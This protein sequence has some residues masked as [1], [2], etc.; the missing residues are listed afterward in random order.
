MKP[1]ILICS[2]ILILMAGC[3]P[4]PQ[5]DISEIL[6]QSEEKLN[7]FEDIETTAS[8]FNGKEDIKFRIMVEGT[9]SEEEAIV[10][11]NKILDSLKEFSNHENFWSYYNGYFDIKNYDEGVIYEA[12]KMKTEKIK[13]MSK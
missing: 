8:A 4:K 7:K 3:N 9:P 10:L 5:F 13:V 6:N 12:T 1:F 2:V 11:F